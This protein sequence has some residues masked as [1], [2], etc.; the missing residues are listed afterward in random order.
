[1][2]ITDIRRLANGEALLAPD[3]GNTDFKAYK[4]GRRDDFDCV[5]DNRGLCAY[6][7]MR[8]SRRRN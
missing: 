1:M 2:N 4:Q 6:H 3:A 8:L 7:E 5:C